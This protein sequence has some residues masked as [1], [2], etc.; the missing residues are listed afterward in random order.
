[1]KK[2]S[3][4]ESKN[5]YLAKLE[6]NRAEAR[7]SPVSFINN[8]CYTFNPKVEPYHL[9]FKLFPFQVNLVDEIKQAIDEGYDIFIDKTREMGAS[10]TTLDVFLWFW[11]N[12]PGSNFLL[13]SRKED[14][15]DNRNG[16]G[17]ELSNKEESL[18][19]KLEYTLRRMDPDMLPKGF[20]FDK[21]FTYMSLLNPE[22]GN[23]ISG[24]SANANF[25]RAGRQKAILLD[26][27]AFWEHDTAAWGSTADTTRCRIV[28]TTPGNIP[29]TKAKR[30]RFG[31]DGEKIKV[32]TLPYYLDPRKDEVW[33]LKERNRRS[34]EDFA[35]EIMIDWEG[36]I[37][38]KVYP[39]IRQ[40]EV[41]KFPY[42]P[43]WPTYI[44]WDFGLDAVAFGFWQFNERN[45]KMRLVDCY[46]N[47]NQPI[48]FYFPFF[49]KQIDST[50]QYNDEDIDAIDAWKDLNA[51]KAIHYGDPD[52]AKRALVSK[53]LE[54]TRSVLQ[55][56]VGI[57]VQ[58]K[59]SANDFGTRREKT[60]VLLQKGIEVNDNPRTK[61]FMES[62]K[63]SAYPSRP[64]NSQSTSPITLPVHNWTSHHRTQL[65]YLCVNFEPPEE[66]PEKPEWAKDQSYS[67]NSKP[68]WARKNDR[69]Q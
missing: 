24:E 27:F 51:K 23:V 36:S 49:T 8:F 68:A 41:G 5:L 35:R 46:T 17:S 14:Y 63:N 29:N 55:A 19:G 37:T 28:L 47:S 26:E 38:G 56:E 67:N 15:V 18:F 13:G 60:K 12:V 25:S 62:I 3:E 58:T 31:T 65:E 30:L 64:D 42:V 2:K 32:I 53:T 33:L 61:I 11:L 40:A 1:M 39:E 57:V 52:V 6:M 59:P 4:L 69:R 9:K 7:L 10:Y 43:N 16:S 66:E 48:H 34:A 21:H 54:S 44:S 20:N 22:N 50:F 45:G